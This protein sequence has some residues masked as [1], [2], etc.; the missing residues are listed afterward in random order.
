MQPGHQMTMMMPGCRPYSKAPGP[1]PAHS[2]ELPAIRPPMQP[3]AGAPT[4]ADLFK[5]QP[6]APT[7]PPAAIAPPTPAQQNHATHPLLD[8]PLTSSDLVRTGPCRHHQRCLAASGSSHMLLQPGS[9]ARLGH[10]CGLMP[11][12][13][14]LCVQCATSR[15]M[16]QSHVSAVNRPQH[17]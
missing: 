9:I 12:H 16:P 7:P 8:E 11:S 5:R 15:S 6:P 17:L 13:T 3:G 4:M 10:G 1:A 2:T 14:C